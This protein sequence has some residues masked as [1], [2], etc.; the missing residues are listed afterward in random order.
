MSRYHT[1]TTLLLFA[2]GY[3]AGCQPTSSPTTSN[4]SNSDSS[5]PSSSTS[6]VIDTTPE[7][8]TGT[9]RRLSAEGTFDAP[10]HGQDNRFEFEMAGQ[11]KYQVRISCA[12]FIGDEWCINPLADV[13]NPTDTKMYA[14]FH[15]VFFDDNGKLVGCCQQD[16]EMEPND[17]P[18]QLGSLVL[19]GPEQELLKASQLKIVIYESDKRIGSEAIDTASTLELVGRDGK[20]I[21]KLDELDSSTT[22]VGNINQ[23]HLTAAVAFEDAKE[24]SR[25]T[26]LN[27]KGKAEYSLYLDTRHRPV[28]IMKSSGDNEMYDRWEVDAEFDPRKRVP[29]V[30]ADPYFALFDADGEL[31]ACVGSPSVGQLVAPEDLLLSTKKLDMVAYE[32]IRE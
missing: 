26:H 4:P 9:T 30:S 6:T 14:A 7:K 8:Q 24:K 11:L 21:T 17:G 19:R 22:S 25:N 1:P 20:V 18:T 15:A 23:I 32:T 10:Q 28:T 27:P 12:P 29:G 16:A 3:L 13:T 5:S 2:L 31:I